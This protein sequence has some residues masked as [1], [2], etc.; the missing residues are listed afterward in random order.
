MKIDIFNTSNKYKI[1]YADPPWQYNDRNVPG[2]AERHYRTM[3]IED[4][5]QL[6]VNQL[7]D[8]NSVL[9]IWVTFPLL[10]EGLDTIKAWGF[11]YTTIGFNWVKWNKHRKSW[12]YGLGSYT[13]SN[14]EICLIGVK[15]DG[16]KRADMGVCSVIDWPVMEH[17][18]KPDIVRK[19][20]VRLLGDVPRIELFAR[21]E[22]KGWDCFG[23]EV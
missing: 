14:S 21:H 18:K 7:A 3:S 12:F 9:F 5:K 8:D 4:I 20:I 13:R 15:G 2:G 10:Q 19:E 23:D 6:P 1:I 17:S 16:L 11:K 22:Y